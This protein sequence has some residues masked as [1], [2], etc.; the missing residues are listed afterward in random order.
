MVSHCMSKVNES[1]ESDLRIRKCAGPIPTEL[2]E[3]TRMTRLSLRNNK[4][5]GR[6]QLAYHKSMVNS[7]SLSN[8]IGWVVLCAGRLPTDLGK[9]ASMRNLTLRSNKFTGRFLG[10]GFAWYASLPNLTFQFK[11]VQAGSQ[12]SLGNSTQLGHC[13]CPT[14]S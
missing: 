12:R 10:L 8:S 2:G 6:F 9:L 5:T 7:T 1:T 11:L 4:L 14:T 3:L 13:F